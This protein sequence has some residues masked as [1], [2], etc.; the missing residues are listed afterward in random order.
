MDAG[1]PHDPSQAHQVR[2]APPPGLHCTRRLPRPPLEVQQHVRQPRRLGREV[3]RRDED[4]REERP[5][6]EF[7]D[8]GAA[9]RGEESE[10]GWVPAVGERRRSG[11]KEVDEF[12]THAQSLRTGIHHTGDAPPE[13]AER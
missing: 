6:D 5:P 2:E 7:L 11:M 10:E 8:E 3:S 13:A 1:A 4:V 12:G 9:A